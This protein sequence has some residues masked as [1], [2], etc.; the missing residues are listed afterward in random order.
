LS[1]GE[2]GK[3]SASAS[4]PLLMQF[5]RVGAGRTLCL[6]WKWIVEIFEVARVA[7]GLVRMVWLMHR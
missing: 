3:L 6:V 7:V 4:D 2:E 5:L 1:K